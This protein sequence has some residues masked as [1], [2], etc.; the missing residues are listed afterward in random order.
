MTFKKFELS[1]DNPSGIYYSGKPYFVLAVALSSNFFNIPLS[2]FNIDL[3]LR[4]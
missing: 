3:Q 2:F 1:V 4:V